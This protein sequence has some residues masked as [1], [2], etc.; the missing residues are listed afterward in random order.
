MVH[1]HTSYISIYEA[2]RVGNPNR[3]GQWKVRRQQM[4]T[5][6]SGNISTLGF[7]LFI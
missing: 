6:V 5:T 3:H 1:E 4:W 7:D 2:M